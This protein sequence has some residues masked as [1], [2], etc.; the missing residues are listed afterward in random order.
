MGNWYCS[1]WSKGLDGHDF[2]CTCLQRKLFVRL[3]CSI[4]AKRK[5]K[6]A[7]V[8]QKSLNRGQPSD[9]GHVERLWGLGTVTNDQRAGWPRF[10][11]YLSTKKSFSL[12]WTGSVRAK[13]KQKAAG[14][15]QVIT[16]ASYL[17]SGWYKSLERCSCAL[18]LFQGLL[19]YLYLIIVASH[20][21][22]VTGGICRV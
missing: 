5:Q 19:L 20:L 14:V 7:R 9:I 1:K 13:R 8:I 18:G 12:D 16:E 22:I 15:L 6:E 4:R 3:T 10:H 11:V 17:I 21:P 2:T